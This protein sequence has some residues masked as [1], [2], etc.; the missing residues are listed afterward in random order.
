MKVT[1]EVRDAVEWAL[2]VGGWREAD[3]VGVIRGP[4]RYASGR[5]VACCSRCRCPEYKDG[6][7]ATERDENEGT[8]ILTAFLCGKCLAESRP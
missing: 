7:Y 5:I 8:P 3:L 2:S 6:L 1:D 4:A